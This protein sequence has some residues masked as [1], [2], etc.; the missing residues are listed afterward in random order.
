M[1]PS[2]AE[3]EAPAG[4]SDRLLVLYASQTGNA[5]DVAERVGR[6]AER[7]GCPTVEVRSMDSFHPVSFN[8]IHNSPC[9][10]A[11]T[12]DGMCLELSPSACLCRVACRGRDSW[13]LLSQPR[14]R[15][16]PQIQ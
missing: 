5:M 8:S 15:G 3:S 11:V 16:T 1:A 10:R 6:E 9:C 14:G 7:G 12:S 4:G 2:A 13:S